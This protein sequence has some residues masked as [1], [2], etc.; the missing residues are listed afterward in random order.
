MSEASG[1]TGRTGTLGDA[2]GW[3]KLALILSLATNLAVAGMVI[4]YSIR[5][6]GEP[7]RRGPER[8]IGWIV[9]MMPEERRDFARAHF[10]DVPELV[11]AAREERMTHLPAVAAA[12]QAEPFDPVALDAALDAMFDRRNSSRT[13][14]RERLISLLAELPPAERAAFAER[15]RER[16]E[17]RAEERQE[18][19]RGD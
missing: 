2:P 4:G 16:L 10:A 3:M 15:F 19:R 8:V 7:E 18:E 9:E 5:G 6:D 1:R 13:L 11:D 14:V 12:M 17:S